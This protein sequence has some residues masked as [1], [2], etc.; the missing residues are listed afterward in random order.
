MRAVLVLALA[1]SLVACGG[2]EAD[3]EDV[4]PTAVEPPSERLVSA[5][6]T[7][8]VT[9]YACSQVRCDVGL[10]W[11]TIWLT[12]DGPNGAYTTTHQECACSSSC[13]YCAADPGAPLHGGQASPMADNATE[14]VQD[15]QE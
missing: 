6:D 4:I 15:G 3:G 5:Q 1:S 13:T 9:R 10:Y 11:E 12:C 8:F 7:C 2:I 14:R